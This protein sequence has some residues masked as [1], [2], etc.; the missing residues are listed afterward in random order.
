M[1]DFKLLAIRPLK[2][3]HRR[4]VKNLNPGTIYPLYNS[5]S[6]LDSK[7]LPI[8]GINN[9]DVVAIKK[10]STFPNTIY[11]QSSGNGKSL[12]ISVSAIAGKNGSG[13]STLI[14]LLFSCIYLHCI[15]TDI[16]KPNLK[17]IISANK[18]LEDEKLSFRFREFELKKSER[19]LRKWITDIENVRDTAFLK[20]L[21]DKLSS[22]TTA[23]RDLQERKTF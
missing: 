17:T 20:N 1:S 21:E 5:Y 16:L 10:N 11:N 4:F 3:C 7:G 15:N 8:T 9:E 6:F 22:F 13:K 19:N 12:R 14:E 18:E 2:G 23:K